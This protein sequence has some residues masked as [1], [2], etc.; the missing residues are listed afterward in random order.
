MYM[1]AF[2]VLPF[3]LTFCVLLIFWLCVIQPR[4][5]LR[6]KEEKEGIGGALGARCQVT[7][8]IDNMAGAGLVSLHGQE[9]AACSLSDDVILRK[10]ETV[11][12]VAVEGVKLI[13]K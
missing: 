2:R 1:L 12:V 5:S 8:D 11:T 4:I 10:G 3:G 9:W 13:C 7:E 6:H